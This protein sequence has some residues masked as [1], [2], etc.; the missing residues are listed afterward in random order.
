MAPSQ[1][2]GDT[3]YRLQQHRSMQLPRLQVTPWQHLSAHCGRA[4]HGRD[5]ELGL[6]TAPRQQLGALCTR[7]Q[8]HHRLQMHKLHV[9]PGQ[10]LG[11]L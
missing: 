4:Q 3:L 1:Q 7:L 6:P 8:K 2:V 9:G 5:W 11:A 10:Q